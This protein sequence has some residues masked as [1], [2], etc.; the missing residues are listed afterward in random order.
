MKIYSKR[1]NCRLCYSKKLKIGFKLKPSPFGDIFF[2]SKKKAIKGHKV[3][4][5][6]YR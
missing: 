2:N 1:K 4:I 5:T 3:P 6:D